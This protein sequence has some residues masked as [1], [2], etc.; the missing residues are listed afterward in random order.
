MRDRPVS[1]GGR[2]VRRDGRV[3][4]DAEPSGG[5][6]AAA[7]SLGRVFCFGSRI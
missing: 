6:D 5:A 1:R 3:R 7:V 4:D 2:A